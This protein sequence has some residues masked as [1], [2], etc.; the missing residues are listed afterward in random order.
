MGVVACVERPD[1]RV[2]EILFDPRFLRTRMKTADP[3]NALLQ[4]SKLKAQLRLW[5]L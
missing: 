4:P 1:S 2:D 3:L 5:E